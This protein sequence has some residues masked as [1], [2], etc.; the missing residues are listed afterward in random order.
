MKGNEPNR[1]IDSIRFAFNNPEILKLL[2]ERGS[3]LREADYKNAVK[4]E[5]EI[6]LQMKAQRE[7]IITPCTAFIRFETAHMRDKIL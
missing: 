3:A 6:S 2:G 7:K 5:N 1:K 4:V